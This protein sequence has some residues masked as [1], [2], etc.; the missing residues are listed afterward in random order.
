MLI[1]VQDVF[2]VATLTVDLSKVPKKEFSAKQS[3]AG[4]RYHKI[5]F[6]LEISIQSALEFSLT[7]NGK[8][9]AAVT[10]EYA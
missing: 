3:P 7:I 8:K 5:H 2:L 1:Q 6:D 4:R 10:A 9:Y